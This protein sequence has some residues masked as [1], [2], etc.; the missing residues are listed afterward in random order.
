[1]TPASYAARLLP[2]LRPLGMKILIEPGR[3]IVGNAGTWSAG[4][5]R[6]A[7]WE[8]KFRDRGCGDE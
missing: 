7:H 2:L 4:G 5:I 3:F 6:E 1:M 8:E